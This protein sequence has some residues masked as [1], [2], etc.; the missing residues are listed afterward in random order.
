[1]SECLEENEGATGE[2]RSRVLGELS[3]YL[4]AL[5]RGVPARRPSTEGAPPDVRVVVRQAE[6][7]GDLIDDERAQA[8]SLA[9]NVFDEPANTIELNPLTESFADIRENLAASYA[10]ASSAADGDMESVSVEAKNAYLAHLDSAIEALRS[11]RLDLEHSAFTDALTGLANRAAFNRDIDHLWETNCPHT[12]AFVDI[13]GLKYCNDHFGHSEGNRYIIEVAN[14]L[15]LHTLPG[16]TAYRLGGDEFIVLSIGASEAELCE[17]LQACRDALGANRISGDD[18]AYSF[19]FGCAHADPDAGDNRTQLM[20]DADKRMYDYKLLH[21]S[22]CGANSSVS[23][24][25]DPQ[26]V[27]SRIFQAMAYSSEGRYLF[28]CNVDTDQ[29][30]WSRNAVRD[31]GLPAEV[32]YHM[33]DVWSAHIHPDDREAWQS[34][35]GEVFSGEKHHHAMSYRAKDASGRYVVVTCTGIRLD[36][37]ADEPTLFVGTIVNRNIADGTDPATGLDDVRSLIAAIDERK[38][39]G[40]SAD[41]VVIKVGGVAE[42]NATYGYEM[43]NDALSQ[44][45]DRLLS[46]VRQRGH[47]YRSYG[48]QFVVM[49]DGDAHVNLPEYSNELSNLL[50]APVHVQGVKVSL[51]VVAAIS[52]YRRISAQSLSVLSEL[53]RRID[54]AVRASGGSSMSDGNPL[55]R[56]TDESVTYFNSVDGLTGL[57]RSSE[58]LHRA[59]V[60]SHK[61]PLE[62]RCIVAL[63]LGHL[64]V[65]NEWYGRG[66]GDALLAEVGS[67]LRGMCEK[68]DGCAGYWGQ[69]DFSIYMPNDPDIVDSLYRRVEAVVASRDDSIGFLP[70]FGVCPLDGGA[71]VKIGDYDK[72]KFALEQAKTDFKSRIKYFEADDYRQR[73]EDHL[74]LS[75]FQRALS[76]NRVFFYVQPQYD[77]I[78]NRIVG[79]EAL[80][81]WRRA[82]GSFLSPAVFVPLLERNGFVSLLDRHIWGEVFAWVSSCLK[83]DIALPPTSIN[84]SQVDIMSL[85]VADCLNRLATRYDVP[86]R[87]VK[88]EITESAYVGDDDAVEALTRKLR[89]L[90]FAVYMDDFGSGRSS[91]SMLKDI[92]VDVVKLDSNFLSP[93]NVE[94][95][96]SGDII[97]SVVDMV[98][99]IDLPIIV[100]G[101]ENEEQVDF[102]KSLGCHYVQGFY[103]YRPMPAEDYEKL[104]ADPSKID[105]RGVVAPNT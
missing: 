34:D 36:G 19:S 1:M 49:L 16:E 88:V 58:F 47:V 48:L 64:R 30:R 74:L 6:W 3:H 20:I 82:D 89:A 14:C 60:Y 102:L 23:T 86:T 83:R 35:I 104:L 39:T 33:G 81:R 52:R 26:G 28:V 40:A 4:D 99:S 72:A 59:T 9:C 101:V 78:E 11:K 62:R 45:T 73:E 80:A 12:I 32:V 57:A 70:S 92:A 21:G 67:V 91:L 43:G 53:N 66:K 50:K 98:H 15:R 61:H 75:E 97:E 13:D 8:R 93:R 76:S 65:F 31:F 27:Q 85:D 24:I 55:M 42:I 46:K 41:F 51:P 71:D 44:I 10:I 25:E 22:Y 105:V 95:G 69:D 84:V 5:A 37:K 87:L 90:G 100:E 18:F 7:L 94:N 54:A 56:L 63:D 77:I 38:R 2:A 17:R 68:V 96:K 103:Y 29:S 79:A